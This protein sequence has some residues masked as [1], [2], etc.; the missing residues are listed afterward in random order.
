[1]VYE[2]CKDVFLPDIE[3]KGLKRVSFGNTGIHE[4]KNGHVFVAGVLERE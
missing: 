3:K 4:I 1:V 2:T